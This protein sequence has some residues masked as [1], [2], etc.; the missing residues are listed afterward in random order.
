M[1]R[2]VNGVSIY[3]GVGKCKELGNGGERVRWVVVTVIV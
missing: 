1:M 3:S 2:G